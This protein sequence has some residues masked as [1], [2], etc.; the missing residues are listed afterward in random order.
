MSFKWYVVHVYSG[1]ELKVQKAL[2]D[3]IETSNCQDKFGEVV[4]PTEQVVELVTKVVVCHYLVQH[5]HRCKQQG[6][7]TK[8]QQM[9][10]SQHFLLYPNNEDKKNKLNYYISMT[11]Q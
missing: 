1:F 4:V 11:I 8:E 10:L 6:P 5:Q 7:R 3:R 2:L 9:K